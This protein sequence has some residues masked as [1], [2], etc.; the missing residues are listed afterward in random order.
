MKTL[1]KNFY[2]NKCYVEYLL[3]ESSNA[4]ILLDGLPTKIQREKLIFELSKYGY[5]VFYPHYIGTWKSKGEFLDHPPT[6]EIDDL[7][8]LLLNNF[9]EN[10]KILQI[11]IISSSFGSAIASCL[12][13]MEFINKSVLLS[14][15]L[16]F[17]KVH[18]ISTLEQ[19]LR[20]N[21]KNEYRF[22]S[23]N[24]EKLVNNQII[25]PAN[26]LK[27]SNFKTKFKI[28]AGKEDVQIDINYLKKFSK[29][30]NIAFENIKNIGHLSYS[31]IDKPMLEKILKWLKS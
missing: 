2:H 5:S 8:T 14:P 6:K 28:F 17:T 19:Y 1:L 15:V 31:K 26:V 13:N 4:I 27:N 22:K 18:G 10:K 23:Y 3:N 9:K 20:D 11:N 30:N 12:S 21:Y 24:W 25:N 29:N 7:I 16:D